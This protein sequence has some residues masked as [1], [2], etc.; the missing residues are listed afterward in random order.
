MRRRP[1]SGLPDLT[2]SRRQTTT[3]A[4][5]EAGGEELTSEEAE[6]AALLH[7]LRDDPVRPGGRAD[8]E[9]RDQVA[10]A[11]VLQDLDLRLELTVVQLRV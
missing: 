5:G 2:H 7:Q 10:V 8:G 4:A 6:Q 9:Q 1:E 3:K 11:E